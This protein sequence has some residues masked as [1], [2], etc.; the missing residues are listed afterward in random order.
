MLPARASKPA[1]AALHP[2]SLFL[3]P[4][5]FSLASVCSLLSFHLG[6]QQEGAAYNPVNPH[7]TLGRFRCIEGSFCCC[8]GLM[9]KFSIVEPNHKTHRENPVLAGRDAANYV[10]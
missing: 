3:S 8:P 2:V 5:K 4:S 1:P 7:S 6:C 10:A 9:E